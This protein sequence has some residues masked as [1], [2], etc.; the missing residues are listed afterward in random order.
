MFCQGRLAEAEVEDIGNTAKGEALLTVYQEVD[1]PFGDLRF[2]F[3]E[4]LGACLCIS[5]TFASANRK[6]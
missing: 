2:T 6:P 3:T 1:F 4:R 5:C